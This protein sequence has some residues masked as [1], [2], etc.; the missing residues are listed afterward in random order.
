M[1]KTDIEK[2]ITKMQLARKNAEPTAVESFIELNK[3]RDPFKIL[4]STIISL[5]TKDEVT[6][7]SSK[8]LFK[9]GS[10]PYAISKLSTHKIQTAIYPCGF[11]RNKAKTIK[12]ISRKILYDYDG[13]TPSSI[14]ELLK[15]KG[16][17][18]K[19]ANLVVILGYNK[20]G[21][22]VDTHVHRIFNRIGYVQTQTP[23]QTEFELRNKLPSKFWSAIN[24]L[25][26]FY[27]Q[28]VCRPISPI[29]SECSV[30]D[31]CKK[32]GV[33]KKR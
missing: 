30:S 6:Y 16:V 25:L 27:G 20:P 1:S 21:I 31:L 33:H 32:I 23:N 15:F 7:E 13:Q 8:R 11:F 19:T 9:L 26:V 18:R 10:T 5:R 2:I 12:E 24:S 14:Q 28:K 29:C 3:K 17:G 4:I 22:C